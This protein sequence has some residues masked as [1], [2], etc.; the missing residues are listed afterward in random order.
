[1]VNSLPRYNNTRYLANNL[2]DSYSSLIKQL[3]LRHKKKELSIAL[4]QPPFFAGLA[5][6]EFLLALSI[7]PANILPAFFKLDSNFFLSGCPA[8][9]YNPL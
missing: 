4:R 9:F 5:G 7:W 2:A 1:M 3:G 6:G 8:C